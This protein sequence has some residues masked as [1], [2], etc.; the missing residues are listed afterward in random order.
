MSLENIKNLQGLIKEA[1]R[2]QSK[3]SNG[4]EFL[5]NGVHQE[6]EKASSQNPG[7][8]MICLMRDFIQKKASSSNFINQKEIGEA[9]SSLINHAG[10]ERSTNFRQVLGKYLPQGHGALPELKRKDASHI[11]G[12]EQ[13]VKTMEE[14]GTGLENLTAAFSGIFSLDS[15]ESIPLQSSSTSDKAKKFASAQLKSL[16]C[17]PKAISVIAENVHFT[18]CKASFNTSSGREVSVEVPVQTTNGAPKLPTQ[19]IGEHGALISLSK[20]NLMFSL[21]SKEEMKRFDARVKLAG[22][23][24]TDSISIDNVT[25]P[26]AL[27]YLLDIEDKVATAASKFDNQQFELARRILASELKSVGFNS[28]VKLAGFSDRSIDFSANIGSEVVSIPVEF[29]MGRPLMP[30]HFK[31]NNKKYSFSSAEFLKVAKLN[32]SAKDRVFSHTRESFATMNYHQLTDEM[33]RGVASKDYTSAEE[34]LK[35]IQANFGDTDV[36]HAINKYASI[37]KTS[38]MNKEREI[39]IS[40]AVKRGDLIQVKTSVDLYSPKYGQPL[41]KLAFDENGKLILLSRVLQRQNQTESETFG[42]SS[43]QIILN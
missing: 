37:L 8:V 26:K 34:A 18:L 14:Y 1:K 43:H 16:G 7:D 21:R 33:I 32:G 2:F 39:L 24:S 30:S 3:L 40:E 6:F 27:D 15:K 41:S 4:M 36:F 12:G 28:Q 9:Y 23:R 11:R 31:H 22:E 29:S 20:E 10:G 17:E 25:A 35:V 13:K 38:G 19:Y 5:S 42:I